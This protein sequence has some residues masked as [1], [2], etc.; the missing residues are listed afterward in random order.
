[1]QLQHNIPVFQLLVETLQKHI[2]ID[3]VLVP[4]ALPNRCPSVGVFLSNVFCECPCV[5]VCSPF[6]QGFSKQFT[7]IVFR[8][9][10]NDSG[11]LLPHWLPFFWII[12][13]C[14]ST[15]KFADRCK[16]NNVYPFF[17]FL[18][19]P[20]LPGTLQMPGANEPGRSE[21]D[22]IHEASQKCWAIVAH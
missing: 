19:S 20:S 9:G 10:C 17:I 12:H 16:N 3:A 6:L 8:Q 7:E 11:Q 13:P 22:G 15:E 14:E 18:L 1:M 21:S 2:H 4:I 5:S